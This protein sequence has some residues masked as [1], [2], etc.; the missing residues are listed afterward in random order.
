MVVNIDGH[1]RYS[2]QIE[3]RRRDGEDRVDPKL[4]Q[5]E[6]TRRVYA[7]RSGKGWREEARKRHAAK[8]RPLNVHSAAAGPSVKSTRRHPKLYSNCR[9]LI[10]LSPS[11]YRLISSTLRAY[12][13]GALPQHHRHAPQNTQ[14]LPPDCLLAEREERRTTPA[15][16]LCTRQTPLFSP[17][18]AS[19]VIPRPLGQLPVSC[20]YATRRTAGGRGGGDEGATRAQKRTMRKQFLNYKSVQA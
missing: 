4:S 9:L 3:R 14:Q 17:A 1:S 8:S 7:E 20:L 18:H 5:T 12:G 19:S 16:A 13:P 11:W 2:H 15:Y 6:A 10:P